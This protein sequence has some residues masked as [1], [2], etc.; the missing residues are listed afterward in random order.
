[1]STVDTP[2]QPLY[3]RAAAAMGF[4]VPVLAFAL[5]TALAAFVAL[6]V[7][8]ALGL[9]HPHWAAMSVWASSQPLR[10]HLLSRSIYRFGGSVVGVIYAVALVLVAQDSLWVLA[11]GLAFWGALC[12]FLGNL[13]RGYMVYGCMLAG[14][15]AAMVV[16][17]HTGPADSIWP[18]AWDRM[19]TVVTGVLAALCISWCFSPRRK[20]AVLI[21]QSRA[22]L[23]GVLQASAARLRQALA[24]QGMDNSSL[25]S[26][27][28]EVEELLELYPE[29]SRTA[30]NAAK[31]MHWQQHHAMEV[32][33]HL[34]QTQSP[35][36]GAHAAQHG[37]LAQSL[38]DLE[39][40]LRAV[41]QS[42]GDGHAA[43]QQALRQAISV[44]ET[45]V[46]R[47]QAVGGSVQPG[48]HALYLLLQEMRR[49]LQAEIQDMHPGQRQANLRADLL[50][51]H[52]D[53]VGARQAG[54]RAGVTLLALGIAWAWTGIGLIGFGMLGLTTMLLVF[55][56]FE[57]PSRTMAFVLRGQIIGA[58]LALICQNLVWPFAQSS[59][60]M[61]WML[62]PFAIMGGLL[63][64]H[65]RTAAGALDTN[66]VMFIL[67]APHFPYSADLGKGLSYALAVVAGPALAWV[68]YRFIYPT[69]GKQRMKTLARMMVD[70]VPAL[71]R[72]LLDEGKPALWQTIGPVGSNFWQGQLHHRVLRLV[73]WADKT[74]LPARD[75]LTRMAMSLRAM[76]STMLQ[77]Q[78][79]RY[80][81]ILATP[82]LR[83]T[84]RMAEI[85]L[86][87]TRAWGAVDQPT[88]A[89]AK[90]VAAWQAL[91][92]QSALPPFLAA[93]ALHI[94]QR[95]VP[96][97]DS[98]RQ[99]LRAVQ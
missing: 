90:V 1:M 86:H 71:A 21:G 56:A 82:A 8:Q 85:A 62:L 99:A 57:S 51:L 96:V 12:A 17:L 28:A 66:M 73:R 64:A 63:F 41:P 53:W 75:Q 3:Q 22:A 60:Q 13:Q 81:T 49:G 95:D 43:L 80:D 35:A 39:Q 37:E 61:V 55:S 16:L 69:D 72:R 30:R 94:A 23:A 20:A 92:Q 34:A 68:V 74:K 26:R 50:P 11:L 54:I 14:Y 76:Q 6:A 15:S 79:W 10:E 70:E 45:T 46:A 84:E 65:K 89:S 52:R 83:R 18:F 47:I 32:V 97:L 19:L 87:R 29:G 40:A 36:I 2:L 78:Q 48:I 33:Y 31:A 7:A 25:L 88:S 4:H 9:E 58:A 42:A 98:A 93:Q 38:D 67:L 77:L 44:C 24:P 59:W 27:L 91:G 5:R